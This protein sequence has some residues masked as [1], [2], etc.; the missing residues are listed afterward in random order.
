MNF[1]HFFG[2]KT[3]FYDGLLP[4]V[5]CLGPTRGDRLLGTLGRLLGALSPSRR[6]R[7]AEALRRIDAEEED[8]RA[9][10]VM[11]RRF[12]ENLFRFLARD[13]ALDGTSDADFFARFDVRGV[14]HLEAALR[15]QRGVI[16]LG[17]HL[18]AHLSATHWLFR[19][20][21][22]LRL[23]VQRAQHVSRLLQNRYDMNTGPHPQTGFFLQRHQSPL[24]AAKRI[25]RTRAALRDGLIVY[26]TGDVP[27][28][29]PNTRP[30]CFLGHVQSYQS[31]WVD[32]AAR[33]QTPVIPVFCTHLPGG[34][35]RLS[36][37]P[38]WSVERGDEDSAMQRF[39]T[40]LEVEIRANPTEAVAHL[41]WPCYNPSPSSGGKAD[42]SRRPRPAA[43]RACLASQERQPS[44]FQ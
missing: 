4:V 38:A 2:W 28:D 7:L 39:L 35:Y 29:G 25:M 44:R 15:R 3:V 36:F 9:S 18:G 43:R 1:R 24:E 10:G 17:S 42:S 27:W 37:D 8:A 13:C 32:L 26:L 19:R 30:G 11:C 12:E 16:L 31:L 41:L 5:R 6:Q 33:F 34:R 20:G 22:P 23:L 40:R 14:E 21:F